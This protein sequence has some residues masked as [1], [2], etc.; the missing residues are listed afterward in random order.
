MGCRSHQPGTSVELIVRLVVHGGDGV[1]Y[2]CTNEGTWEE[3]SWRL[4]QAQ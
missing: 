1:L 2:L 4:R 3:E